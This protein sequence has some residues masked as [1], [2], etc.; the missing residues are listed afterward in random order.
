M[1]SEDASFITGEILTIDGGQNLTTNKYEDFLKEIESQKN[2]GGGGGFFGAA[3]QKW[4]LF[5]LYLN[6]TYQSYIRMSMWI[7]ERNN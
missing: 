6:N 7:I 5:D 1:A 4:F 3:T 2:V